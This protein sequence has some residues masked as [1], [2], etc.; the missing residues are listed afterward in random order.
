MTSNYFDML[1]RVR[2]SYKEK[3]NG[4]ERQDP[5]KF[6]DWFEWLTPI[7]RNVWSDIRNL[8]LPFYPQ[9][10]AGP[11][12]LDF[13]DP[14]KKI[15]LEID[16][17][18]HLDAEVKQRDIKKDSYLEK[19]GW[20]VIRIQGWKTYKS[21]EDYEYSD[22]EIE[23]MYYCDQPI[24]YVRPEYWTDCSEGILQNIKDRYY[25]D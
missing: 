17:K 25:R 11:Y 14:F 23:N 2:Q 22:R 18:I 12:Y 21:R 1:K 13:A 8:G 9:F 15:A 10:P 4:N 5:Y 16:G 6:S 20:T 3:W 7:E 24:E 19:N